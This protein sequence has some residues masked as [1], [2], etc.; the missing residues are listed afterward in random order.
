MWKCRYARKDNKKGRARGGFIIGN[1]K[2]GEIKNR[3]LIDK[4]GED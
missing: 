2:G 4:S 3:E 1:K